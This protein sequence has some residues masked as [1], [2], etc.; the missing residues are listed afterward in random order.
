MRGESGLSFEIS[1]DTLGLA[2]LEIAES[3][4]LAGRTL[5]VLGTTL[6]KFCRYKRTT[7]VRDSGQGSRVGTYEIKIKGRFSVSR[8]GISED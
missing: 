3:D 2:K 4:W 7:G 1:L 8:L 6:G 5:D